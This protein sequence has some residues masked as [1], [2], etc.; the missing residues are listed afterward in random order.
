MLRWYPYAKVRLNRGQIDRA[1]ATAADFVAFSYLDVARTRLLTAGKDTGFWIEVG[2]G[3]R[4][5]EFEGEE[6]RRIA[7]SIIPRLNL[8]GGSRRMVGRAVRE[9]ESEGHSVRFVTRV[10]ELGDRG[11]RGRSGFIRSMPKSTR[12]AI[13]MAL[14]EEQERRALDGELWILEQAWKEAEEI[15]AIS[16]RLLLPAGTDAGFRAVRARRLKLMC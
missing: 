10:A 13:E 15:A 9:I 7:A 2:A 16:D 14:H 3:R 8:W 4:K 11:L 5:A 12:L 6:A 1:G